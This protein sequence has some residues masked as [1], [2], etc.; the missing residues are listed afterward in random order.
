MRIGLTSK[1]RLP[2]IVL[3]IAFAIQACGS[4]SDEVFEVLVWVDE[5]VSEEDFYPDGDVYEAPCGLIRLLKVRNL[6]ELSID[7]YDSLE[8]VLE[9]AEN[10][11]VIA[12]WRIPV[13]SYVTSI[14]A[15]WL[16]VNSSD[17]HISINLKGDI[18]RAKQPET[19]EEQEY[20]G[21]CPDPV[22]EDFLGPDGKSDYLACWR[23]KDRTSNKTRLVAYQGVCT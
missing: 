21:E 11:D 2:V 14:D 4:E 6:R 8:R 16:I 13:E 18:R 9:F 20:F 12:E 23:L 17:G 10:G 7:Q 22:L 3:L 15:E 19:E 5:Q 1:W